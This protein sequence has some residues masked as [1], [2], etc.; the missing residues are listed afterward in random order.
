MGDHAQPAKPPPSQRTDLNI[1]DPQISID[2]LFS[3]CNV[4]TF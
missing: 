2:G 1:T 4:D 3:F